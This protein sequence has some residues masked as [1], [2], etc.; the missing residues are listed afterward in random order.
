MRV[1][2]GDY[3]YVKHALLLFYDILDI[4]IRLLL[5]LAKNS[6]KKK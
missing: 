6:K 4:F 2:S 1:R 3:D 5:L